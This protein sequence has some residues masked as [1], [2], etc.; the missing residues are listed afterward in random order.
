MISERYLNLERGVALL[1]TPSKLLEARLNYAARLDYATGQ[2]HA[3][4]LW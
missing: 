2:L 4:L 3:D 1:G